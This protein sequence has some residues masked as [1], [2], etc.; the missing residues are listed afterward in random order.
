M[1][2]G[3]GPGGVHPFGAVDKAFLENC[4]ACFPRDTAV[5][6]NLLII[7]CLDTAAGFQKTGM[8]GKR[9]LNGLPCCI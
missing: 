9:E 3:T 4:S 5:F 6:E 8:A 1:A 7:A 2:S